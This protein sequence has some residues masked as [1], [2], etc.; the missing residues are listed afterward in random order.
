MLIVRLPDGT[1]Q[2]ISSRTQ[3][4]RGNPPGLS[5]PQLSREQ[6]LLEVVDGM[7]GV[8]QL[9]NIGLSG[10]QCYCFCM[11]LLLLLLP[12]QMC[13]RSDMMCLTSA[14]YLFA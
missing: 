5:D 7:E 11:L 9:T 1:Q 12:L 2:Q 14:S 3:Y 10:E 6:I 8:L 4:G 13:S